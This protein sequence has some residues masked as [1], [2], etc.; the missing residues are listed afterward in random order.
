MLDPH[1]HL[2]FFA[3]NGQC[4]LDLCPTGDGPSACGQTASC[5]ADLY[6]AWK[7]AQ[8]VAWIHFIF[9]RDMRER[10][11]RALDCLTSFRRRVETVSEPWLSEDVAGLGR[12]RLN[13]LSKL[14]DHDV[15][16]LDF[17][18]VFWSPNGLQNLRVRDRD[19]RVRNKILKNCKLFG[20]EPHVPPADGDVMTAQI[21]A[22]F[23]ECQDRGALA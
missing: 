15:K 5:Q 20:S 14:V 23:I 4:D 11:G 6:E 17:V 9:R 3:S 22:Y 8:R 18:S 19:I 7:V 10:F 2:L 1:K 12:I 16:I 13:L 21:H